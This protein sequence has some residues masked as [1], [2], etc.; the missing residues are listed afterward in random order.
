MRLADTRRAQQDDVLLAL[1]EAELVQALD[2]LTLDRRLKGEVE[3]LERLDRRE[4]RRAHR[5]HQ[6]TVVA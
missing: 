3:I 1:E 2:L 4:A 5:S 6:S